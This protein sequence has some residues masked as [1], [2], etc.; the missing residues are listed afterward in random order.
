VELTARYLISIS[1]RLRA[2]RSPKSSETVHVV[3]MEQPQEGEFCKATSEL[4]NEVTTA[5]SKPDRCGRTVLD[6]APA[7]FKTCL[8]A[9]CRRL[10][11]TAT[12]T[13]NHGKWRHSGAL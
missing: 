11:H 12:P 7:V 4:M 1:N 5:E 3:R 13:I 8:W 6:G 9:Q 10:F 2:R